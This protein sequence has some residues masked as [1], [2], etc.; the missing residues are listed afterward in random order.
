MRFVLISIG[1]LLSL[2]SFS[3][4]GKLFVQG[5]G[6]EFLDQ[7]VF[8]QNDTIEFYF[9]KPAGYS[10][11][12]EINYRLKDKTINRLYEISFEAEELGL[13]RGVAIIQSDYLVNNHS[14]AVVIPSGN[15]GN[16]DD[17]IASGFTLTVK[18]TPKVQDFNLLNTSQTDNIFDNDENYVVLNGGSSTSNNPNLE[19]YYY[20]DGVFE[21]SPGSGFY[22]FYPTR[23]PVGQNTVYYQ[24]KLN[25]GD[26]TCVADPPSSIDVT[27]NNSG[28]FISFDPDSKISN[29]NYLCVGDLRGYSTTFKFRLNDQEYESNYINV[30]GCKTVTNYF[31][32]DVTQLYIYYY[33]NG[34]YHE[35]PV[36]TY[37]EQDVPDGYLVSGS[38]N[39]PS[40]IPLDIQNFRL[41]VKGNRRRVMSYIGPGCPAQDINDYETNSTVAYF[42]PK[43]NPNPKINLSDLSGTF[44]KDNSK[45]IQISYS[46]NETNADHNPDTT[47]G[48]IKY[49]F[50]GGSYK[51]YPSNEFIPSAFP[52]GSYSFK[53]VHNEGNKDRNFC[54][55]ESSPI[56]LK[57][58]P[59]PQA[60]TDF[61]LKACVGDTVEFDINGIKLDEASYVWKFGDGDSLTQAKDKRTFD[62]ESAYSV[63][64][65]V[66]SKEGCVNISPTGFINVTP[67][68]EIDFS[69][70]GGCSEYNTKVTP[71][72]L[73]SEVLQV[74]DIDSWEWNYINKQAKTKFYK[75]MVPLEDT[76]ES[77]GMYNISLTATSNAGCETTI[78][79][80]IFIQPVIEVFNYFETFNSDTYPG[81]ISSGEIRSEVNSSWVKLPQF[82]SQNGVWA[83]S[84]NSGTYYN[85]EKSFLESPCFILDKTSLPMMDLTIASETD[86]QADGAIVEYTVDG[87]ETWKK[88]GNKDAGIGWYNDKNLLGLPGSGINNLDQE[89][90]TGI[91]DWQRA[92]YQLNDVKEEQIKAAQPVKFRFA[93][94]SNGDNPIDEQL[95]GFA[96]DKFSIVERNRMMVIETFT[97][98]NSPDY[99]IANDYLEELLDGK[100]DEVIDIRYHIPDIPGDPVYE[101]NRKDFSAKR[102]HYGISESPRTVFDGEFN[103]DL[104]FLV[105]END[106]G[107]TVYDRKSLITAPFDLELKKEEFT[108]S[109][110][111]KAII[112]KNITIEDF[113]GDLVLMVG[114]VQKS[115]K[116][117]DNEY[118]N[119]LRKFIPNAGGITIE[120][121][122]PAADTSSVEVDLTW[123]TDYYSDLELDEDYRFVAY[124]FRAQDIQQTKEIV[125]GTYVD[126]D[127]LPQPNIITGIDDQVAEDRILVYPNPARNSIKLKWPAAKGRGLDYE[128][129]SIN[130]S[131]VSQGRLQSANEAIPVAEMPVGIY[132][133]KIVTDDMQKPVIKRFSIM[134]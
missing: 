72:L 112:T 126:V 128:I 84:E 23:V 48:N 98:V 14:F 120:G 19:N 15:N 64:L 92:A 125:Q 25:H 77:N 11:N 88:F 57:V 39:I 73:N 116:V 81:W 20:G 26:I 22:R 132:Y 94:G 124:L 85:N 52:T 59:L 38:F 34:S 69:Y 76:F 1:F 129:Y 27:I 117:G 31:F 78:T 35:I 99:Q 130:G 50:E 113:E 2:T 91:F 134:R 109:I 127:Q 75:E 67:Y 100:E 89:G 18:E 90:W 107:Q 93:F 54:S 106:F 121:D 10:D 104:N 46:F 32:T 74:T 7:G 101:L 17:V 114:L 16:P 131:F 37:T 133:L 44:C 43:A 102:L 56:T 49:S 87:G 8:C 83:T 12:D 51:I 3:Q 33:Y 70:L 80:R 123:K 28:S 41:R 82:N 95:R 60:S 105:D 68:P 86:E 97:N 110:S 36:N 40:N 96:I 45:E 66:T 111:L 13:I 119:I 6:G 55:Q 118:K 21:T 108:D 42:Y 65:K 9:N 24:P 63:S 79:N 58:V 47:A 30:D 61:P 103:K 115:L 71:Q 53:Y 29:S 5:S 4:G 122:W 62:R